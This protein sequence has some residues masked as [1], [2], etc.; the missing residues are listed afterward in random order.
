M[1]IEFKCT[2]GKSLAAKDEYAGRRLRCPKCQTVLFIPQ[3]TAAPT[4]VL[5]APTRSTVVPKRSDGAIARPVR[6]VA[7]QQSIDL[8]STP[9][10]PTRADAETVAAPHATPVALPTMRATTM[11][12]A[13]AVPARNGWPEDN[14]DQSITPW[15]PG[16]DVRFGDRGS[17]RD[18]GILVDWL[19]PA[20]LLV[21]A[22]L[23]ILA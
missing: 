12:L 4:P 8:E 15:Q 19:V 10:S 20:V 22:F 7:T 17:D 18:W 13:S 11:P 6:A 14:F 9:V 21:V 16:D 23:F 5:A 3:P 2:C 1:A